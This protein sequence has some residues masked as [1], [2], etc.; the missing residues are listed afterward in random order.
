MSIGSRLV[1][2]ET[3]NMKE[4]AAVELFQDM[5]N[6]GVVWD[7]PS[8]SLTAKSLVLAGKCHKPNGSYIMEEKKVCVDTF[9][10]NELDRL[11]RFAVAYRAKR[12]KEPENF[13]EELT[14]L[15][16]LQQYE[17]WIEFVM[18]DDDQNVSIIN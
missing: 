12:D 14:E 3:G 6:I 4:E 5:I 9:V 18:N 13:P 2:Y 15:E 17:D 7:D 16:F 10:G 1:L 11:E 8:Y